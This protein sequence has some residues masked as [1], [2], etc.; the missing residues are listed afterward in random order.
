MNSATILYNLVSISG[1]EFK[2]LFKES[3]VDSRES[4]LAINTKANHVFTDYFRVHPDY[5]GRARSILD[6]NSLHLVASIPKIWSL[7]TFSSYL[8]CFFFT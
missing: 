1:V 2:S 5:V 8:F 6:M 7:C 4:F 3:C